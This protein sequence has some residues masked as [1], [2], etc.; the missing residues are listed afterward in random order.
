MDSTKRCPHC[1]EE[2]LA[3]AM[4]CKHC[5]S[6][7]VVHLSS[8]LELPPHPESIAIRA[9]S[10]A[11]PQPRIVESQPSVRVDFNARRAA[12]QVEL[13]AFNS[14]AKGLLGVEAMAT[15]LAAGL[16]KQSLAVGL[17]ALVAIIAMFFN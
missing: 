6:D 9:A 11:P 15:A 3:A 7:L 16:Y 1:A 12:T 17:I 13:A 14:K 2:I 4:K 10:I 5:K 8:E